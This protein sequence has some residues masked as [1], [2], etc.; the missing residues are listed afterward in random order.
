MPAHGHAVLLRH[1]VVRLA[2]IPARRRFVD[3]YSLR[4]AVARHAIGLVLAL[5]PVEIKRVR[6][7]VR[8]DPVPAFARRAAVCSALAVHANHLIHDEVHVA[9]RHRRDRAAQR[10]AS[11]SLAVEPAQ[12]LVER[13]VAPAGSDMNVPLVVGTSRRRARVVDGNVLEGSR[14][15][16]A[17]QH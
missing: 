5:D 1:E 14:R 10:A 11:L 2:S 9:R 17:R 8:A 6:V 13:A 15:T 4:S 12:F 3:Q 16:S 7:A